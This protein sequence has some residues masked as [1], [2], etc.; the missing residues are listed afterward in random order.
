MA[1]IINNG[2]KHYGKSEIVLAGVEMNVDVGEIYGL[3]G[4]SGCGKTTLL[5]CIVGLHQL[6]Y[7][8]VTV[9]QKSNPGNL[10]RLCGYMPQEFALLDTLTIAETLKYFGM[11]YTMTSVEI[12]ERIEFL[13]EFLDLPEISKL[14]QALS[15]GQKRRVSLAA[16]MIHN[17]K[18]LVLDEP[19]VGLD[20]LLRQRIWKY[21]YKISRDHGTSIIIS[22]HY[23]EETKFCDRVGIMRGGRL[24]AEDSPNSLLRTHKTPTIEKLVLKLCQHDQ[25]VS[26]FTRNLPRFK[27]LKED[28]MLE[29]IVL[30]MSQAQ[31]MSI[32]AASSNLTWDNV[33]IIWALM[34]KWFH[35]NRRDLRMHLLQLCLPTLIVLVMQHVLGPQPKRIKLGLVHN[36]NLNFTDAP[37]KFCSANSLSQECLSN[38]GICNFVDKLDEDQFIWVPVNSY[39]EGLTYIK[40]GK[41]TGLVEFPENYVTHVK[42]R[43]ALTNF[44]DN[45]T[46]L[47]STISIRLDE[48][49]RMLAFWMRK[50]IF[51]K[52]MI[53]A[54]NILSSC[55]LPSDVS[56][57][58]LHFRAIYGAMFT[59]ALPIAVIHVEDK[60]SGLVDRDNV[61]GVGFWHYLI[62]T[63]FT[64]SLTIFIQVGAL[65]GIV[66]G[67][68]DMVING[69]WVVALGLMYMASFAGLSV[70][71]LMSALW[72]GLLENILVLLC[73]LLSMVFTTGIYWPLEMMPW[74]FRQLLKCWPTTLMVEA[75]RSICSR[76]WGISNEIVAAGFISGGCWICVSLL[77]TMFAGRWR[78][79]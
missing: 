35:R 31:N 60:I 15:G 46:I 6:D 8:S 62:A 57:P 22:T 48:T 14:V 78:H 58:P 75:M 10:G 79:K 9:F 54:G 77:I 20:S 19:S 16:A 17:P 11:L 24:L 65:M 36:S 52:Y 73:I 23:V 43:M 50:T 56:R 38:A 47:G 12:K 27:Y 1:M 32:E 29:A 55:S 51:E 40:Q 70:G 72:D 44:A 71:F 37:Q 53:Y 34:C 3:L 61:A 4:A 18:L 68:Y 26:N 59:V 41:T 25:K 39:D 7:G 28:D 13:I 67:F 74:A 30:P 2:F 42:N 64:H 63:F 45:A 5:K 66:A 21:L 69:S 33:S 49:D 76:G